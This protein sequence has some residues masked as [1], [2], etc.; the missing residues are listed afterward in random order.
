MTRLATPFL[1]MAIPKIFNQLLIFMNFYQHAKNQAISS[2]CVGDIA[3]LKILQS[4]W[5][6]ALPPKS[7]EPD[8]PK[9]G[10]FT[11]TYH[12]I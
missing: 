7:Q 8:F 10:I 5:Q 4:D 12:I 9:Y 11:R 6:R 3:D 2:F 1:N